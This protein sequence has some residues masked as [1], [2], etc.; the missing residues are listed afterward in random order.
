MT[1][2]VNGRNTNDVLL[3][4][5]GAPSYKTLAD[6]LR[7][8]GSAGIFEGGT[9]TNS[10]SG[11]IDVA[12]A[13]GVIRTSDSET[14]KLVSFDIAA[15][16]DVA[17]TDNS[18]NYIYI[19]YNSG[20]PIYAVTTDYN[21]I[22]FNTQVIVGRVY[23]SGTNL[24]IA[25]IGQYIADHVLRDL[26][27]VQYTR[28]LEWGSGSALGFVTATRQ[29]TVGAGVYFSNYTK[30]STAAFD[31][32][33][34]DRFTTWYR[35]GS[36]GWTAVTLQ[37]NVDNLNYDNGSGTLTALNDGDYGVH[38]VYQLTDGSI[39]IQYGQATYTSIANAR[40]STV[41][42]SQPPV[43]VAMGVLVGRIIIQKNATQ[44][45]E[46][47]SAFSYTF[48]GTATTSHNDLANID[49]GGTYHLSQPVA[50]STAR[51][52]NVVA[53]DNGE[54]VRSNKALFDDSKTPAMN[55]SVSTGVEMV[56][57][58]IDHVHPVDTSRAP[59]DNP[60]FTTL[61][62]TPAL[63]VTGGTPGV[64]KVL[65]SDADGDATWQ[66]AAGGG[67]GEADIIARAIIFGGI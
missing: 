15:T 8:N 21:A 42:S 23:R 22:N 43:V 58:R 67:M 19:D 9:I 40:N 25:N 55:G 57:A 60:T 38:W 50:P 56:V 61:V 24:N 66:D 47:S 18:M 4:S 13:K 31:A 3:D 39:H 54:T 51:Y 1:I 45:Y 30:V 10:G 64:G 28:R 35:N 36:G 2:K 16:T 37:Q 34:T 6:Y 32:S 12:A 11:Q 26:Y 27:R 29:P 53:I 20:S 33:G 48:T 62:T 63:K 49:G 59:V 17:L 5:I 44:I 14:G 41:P 52:R 65:T 46:V 7:A